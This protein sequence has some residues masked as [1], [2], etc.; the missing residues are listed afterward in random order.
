MLRHKKICTVEKLSNKSFTC[1]KCNNSFT[2]K[3]DLNRHITKH[4]SYGCD[5]CK[6][7]FDTQN[8][9]DF[10][11]TLHAGN[12]PY[13]CNKCNKPFRTINYLICHEKA[14]I[15]VDILNQ[16][17]IY[18]KDKSLKRT[19]TRIQLSDTQRAKRIRMSEDYDYF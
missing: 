6:K 19:R 4:F 11:K 1:D 17:E 8:E 13:K 10:H 5:E 2:R 12:A 7:I 3:H 15:C 9:L 18:I 16:N 14:Q